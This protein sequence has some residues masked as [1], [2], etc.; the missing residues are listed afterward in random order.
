MKNLC[1]TIALTVSIAAST[2]FADEA[3]VQFSSLDGFNAPDTQ[4]VKG[5]RFPALYGK[6]SNVVGADL[7]LLAIGETDN[8]KGVQ[9]PLLIVGA[10]H[11]NESMT[12]AAFGLWNWNKGTAK[13][14]H[15]GTVNV[16]NDVHGANL[17]LVN[18]STGHTVFDWSAANIS[19]SSNVQL[20]IFN[21]TDEV[22]TFQFGLI[23]C[24]KN[25]FLPCFPIINFAVKK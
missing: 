23:N 10:N 13:G 19:K 1:T 25:G 24:A 21:K 18:Y 12:G 16:T 11:V 20:G 15:F 9:F 2:S 4:N 6:T 8:F 22:K 14:V 3:A 5:V 17:G 7:H